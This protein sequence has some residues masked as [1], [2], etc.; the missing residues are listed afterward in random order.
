MPLRGSS[1]STLLVAS[2]VRGDSPSSS[3][4]CSPI[5]GAGLETIQPSSMRMGAP[6]CSVGPA[7]VCSISEKK[8]RSEKW[9]SDS[10]SMGRLTAV[11][12]HPPAWASS[13]A[14]CLSRPRVHAK[15]SPSASSGKFSL[16]I[17]AGSSYK[18]DISGSFMTA[19]I[20]GN[21]F[22]NVDT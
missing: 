2:L 20:R 18:A 15:S 21:Q 11:I 8:P 13:M 14:C 6:G 10:R 16:R 4:W 22:I 12:G 7:L 3:C 5:I 19:T 9:G 17:H 1:S